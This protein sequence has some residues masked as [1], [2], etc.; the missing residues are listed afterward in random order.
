LFL[1]M[2]ALWRSV[3]EMALLSEVTQTITLVFYLVYCLLH[4][5]VCGG[6]GLKFGLASFLTTYSLSECTSQ[7]N[8][9]GST[10]TM[11]FAVCVI[12]EPSLP[13]RDCGYN[14]N[15]CHEGVC[16]TCPAVDSEGQRCE[17]KK[18][19]LRPGCKEHRSK[20]KLKDSQYD[21]FEHKQG[22]EKET[23]ED[24]EYKR[25]MV[26]YRKAIEEETPNWSD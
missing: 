3:L 22:T 19:G 14:F 17:H 23:P 16:F 2:V 5:L 13:C 21:M 7:S 9:C 24:R 25:K 18:D 26:A 15:G 20:K 12:E 1:V 8:A 4:C 11:G 6:I 10:V